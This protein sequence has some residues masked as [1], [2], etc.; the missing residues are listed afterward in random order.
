MKDNSILT[1]PVHAVNIGARLLG[2]AL[3]QQKI[4]VVILN[5]K[6]PIEVH[7]SQR[8]QEILDKME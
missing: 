7:L 6:P 3:E 2:E 4:D 1:S 5:W 8:I